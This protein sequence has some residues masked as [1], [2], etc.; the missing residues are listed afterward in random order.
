MKEQLYN[1]EIK[2]GNFMK[3]L[4]ITKDHLE[5]F[6]DVFLNDCMDGKDVDNHTIHSMQKLIGEENTQKSISIALQKAG[7]EERQITSVIA[8]ALTGGKIIHIA[9]YVKEK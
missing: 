6:G 7:I 1:K 9:T 3:K 2:K 5:N 8:R 4:E